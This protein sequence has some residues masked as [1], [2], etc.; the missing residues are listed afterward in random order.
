MR[1]SAIPLQGALLLFTVL[2]FD[3][4]QGMPYTSM[5]YLEA[6]GQSKPREG[7]HGLGGERGIGNGV[8]STPFPFRKHGKPHQQVFPKLP[9]QSTQIKI[10]KVSWVT[11]IA[12]C[13]C[14]LLKMFK[15]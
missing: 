8:T 13:A 3:L 11:L 9:G 10:Q 14:F 5:I 7:F 15:D 12:H 1:T 4:C 6:T 2:P